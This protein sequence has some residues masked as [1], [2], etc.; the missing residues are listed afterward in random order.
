MFALTYYL[1]EI[2]GFLQQLLV[3]IVISHLLVQINLPDYHIYN[4]LY[5]LNKITPLFTFSNVR[6]HN[7]GQT[8]FPEP[9]NLCTE[10]IVHALDLCRATYSLWFRSQVLVPV[11]SLQQFSDLM[12]DTQVGILTCSLLW[13]REEKSRIWDHKPLNDCSRSCRAFDSQLWLRLYVSQFTYSCMCMTSR[14]CSRISLRI[15]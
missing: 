9:M 10:R 7:M 3:L 5:H 1:M 12:G 15:I 11:F 14:F 2:F 6:V 8:A 4:L 13:T